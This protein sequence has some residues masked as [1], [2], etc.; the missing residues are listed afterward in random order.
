MKMKDIRWEIIA[1][2]L[3]L[4][5]SLIVYGERTYSRYSAFVDSSQAQ[6]I[7]IDHRTGE[8]I[9][10]FNRRCTTIL[11][12]NGKAPGGFT[13]LEDDLRDAE[14]NLVGQ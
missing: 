4:G 10:C 2:S 3:I 14:Q 6:K 8:M 13:D 5:A 12:K 1:G 7:R 9:S 11:M